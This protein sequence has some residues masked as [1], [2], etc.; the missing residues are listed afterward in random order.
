MFPTVSEFIILYTSYLSWLLFL[1]ICL[2]FSKQKRRYINHLIFYSVY[3]GIM[4]YVFSDKQN[5]KYGG[6]LPVLFYGGVFLVVH[7][8]SFICYGIYRYLTVRK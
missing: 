5:F 1:L 8:L 2:L 4:L 6:S 7:F 3:S